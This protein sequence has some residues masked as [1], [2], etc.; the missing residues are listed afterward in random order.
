MAIFGPFVFF[1]VLSRSFLLCCPSMVLILSFCLFSSFAVAFVGFL[2]TFCLFCLFFTFSPL[3][4]FL[5]L[6][7]LLSLFWPLLGVRILLLFFVFSCG[8]SLALF[9]SFFAFLCRLLYTFLSLFWS[10]LF[11]LVSFSS[12]LF[13]CRLVPILSPYVGVLLLPFF[14]F[15][16]V[17]SVF[18]VFFVLISFF[19][20]HFL[21][22]TWCQ[23]F[24][25][26]FRFFFCSVSLAPFV[27]IFVLFLVPFWQFLS[28]F[29]PLFGH[30]WTLFVLSY[31]LSFF[32]L[33][34]TFVVFA[35]LFWFFYCIFSSYL[36]C[37]LY[38][39][40][41]TFR[42]FSSMIQFLS[43]P[44]W[45]SLFCPLVSMFNYL[46]F[47]FFCRVS[48]ALFVP[49]FVYFWFLF[50]NFYLCFPPILASFWQC[51][52]PFYCF[53]SL[54]VFFFFIVPLWFMICLFLVFI[55]FFAQF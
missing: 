30:F 12:F 18:C 51:L 49:I 8:V 10:F 36:L 11:L 52:D 31:P 23:C 22:P 29:W 35:F 50:G 39:F 24:I 13:C 34:C 19:I 5:S 42:P 16:V 43:R 15:C 48:L 3:V 2:D 41:Y 20:V 37:F 14:V 54:V 17:F 21:A 46:F 53:L 9:V 28:Q 40:K 47:V 26:F 44:P 4:R 55:A 33:Y 25:A 27:P 32:L 38:F 45:L 6:P 1:L 7:P